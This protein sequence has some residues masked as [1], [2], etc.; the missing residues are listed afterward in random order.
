MKFIRALY[1]W[2]LDLSDKK[3][4]PLALFILATAESIFFPIPP[5]VLLIALSIGSRKKSIRFGVLCVSGSILGAVIG[6][7]IGYHAWWSSPGNYSPFA[8]FFFDHVPGFTHSSFTRISELYNEYNFYIIFTAG[9]T[10][11]PYKVFTLTAGAYAIN[12]PMFIIASIVSRST[13]FLLISA[14]IWKFGSPIKELIEK[15]FNLFAVIF[16]VLLIGSFFVLKYL[17]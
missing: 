6:Y 8:M 10:P 12:F 9:L 13:R 5:D 4:G 16:T 1:D 3:S 17:L 15:Y 7:S 11:L 2:V 14:L